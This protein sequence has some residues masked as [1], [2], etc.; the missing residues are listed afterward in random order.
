[1]CTIRTL[2]VAAAAPSASSPFFVVV[3][4]AALVCLTFFLWTLAFRVYST[5]GAFRRMGERGVAQDRV[6][7]R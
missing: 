6:L 4:D 3:D 7:H 5:L 2:R 1:M